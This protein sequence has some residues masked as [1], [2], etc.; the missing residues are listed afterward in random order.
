MCS[1]IDHMQINNTDLLLLH[2][3]T[4]I[5]IIESITVTAGFVTFSKF[6]FVL[7][8]KYPQRAIN[9][10]KFYIFIRV[11]KFRKRFYIILF[12][13]FEIQENVNVFKDVSLKNAF[14]RTFTIIEKFGRIYKEG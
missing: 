7:F 5:K 4:K 1:T 8:I 3:Y 12:F 2:K 11:I 10:N 9:V 6:F 14:H 13:K